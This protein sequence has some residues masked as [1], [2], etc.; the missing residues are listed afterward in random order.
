MYVWHPLTLNNNCEL[1]YHFD[2]FLA[3]FVDKDDHQFLCKNSR[4]IGNKTESLFKLF[5]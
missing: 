3:N 5:S 1:T 4:V 2:L